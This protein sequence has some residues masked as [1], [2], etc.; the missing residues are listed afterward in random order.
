MPEKQESSH[1][2]ENKSK[3]NLKES[4]EYMV[5]TQG[6]HLDSHEISIL[7]LPSAD[8]DLK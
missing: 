2:T 3:A 8:C 1:R 7:L 5:F 4:S 6:S